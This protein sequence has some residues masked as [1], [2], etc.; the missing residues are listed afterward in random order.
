MP[1]KETCVMDERLKFIGKYLRN[2]SSMVSLCQ[3]FNIS[4]KT[5]YNLIQRYLLEG[6][7]GLYDRSRAPHSHPY[8][9]SEDIITQILRLREEHPDWGPRKL[10]EWLKRHRPRTQWPCASTIGRIL[11]R[12]GKIVPHKRRSKT[13]PYTQPF[14]SSTKPNMIWCADFKGWFSTGDGKRC[15]PLTVTDSYSRYVL[16]CRALSRGT[17]AYVRSV[18]ESL[19]RKYGLPWAIRTDNGTP[20]ASGA[21][22]GLSRLSVWWIKLGILPERI[23]PG[24]PEQNGR[25]ERFHRTLKKGAISPARYS[26]AHQQEAFDQFCR[27]YNQERPHE[28]LDY[29]TP[30]DCYHKSQRPLPAKP[31]EIAYPDHMIVRKVRA[32]GQIWWKGK[33]PFVSETLVG[34]PIGLEQIDE[35][36]F[37][38]HYGPFELAV[39]DEKKGKL[40]KPPVKWKKRY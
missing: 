4:R 7:V 10:L 27:E 32:S 26:L 21:L 28:A 13:P 1:W 36:T 18:F 24:H 29:Q 12:N 38:I 17:H 30:S 14:I 6:P 37:K 20:F 33:E 22:G 11:S 25:H 2:E 5:G 8:A 40:I 19:F 16:A 34:E 3:E 23:E 31:L 39:L 9:V 15:E 35:F